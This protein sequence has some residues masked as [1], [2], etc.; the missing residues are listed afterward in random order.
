MQ[1]DGE[2]MMHFIERMVL[3]ALFLL[4]VV[5][6]SNKSEA[7]SSTHQQAITQ[8]IHPDQVNA[9]VVNSAQLPSF[10][11][12]AIKIVDQLHLNLSDWEMICQADNQKASHVVTVL[13]NER[14][15]IPFSLVYRFYNHLFPKE[16]G[17]VPILS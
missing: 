7:A 8:N 2:N 5:A 1:K 4:F 10:F 17:E 15:L 3:M 14:R 11:P 6:F 13:Q 16:S 9:L 12:K